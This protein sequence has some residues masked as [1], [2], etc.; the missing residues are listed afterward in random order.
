MKNTVFIQ[1]SVL[2]LICSVSVFFGCNKKESEG[3]SPDAEKPTSAFRSEKDPR[4]DISADSDPSE[5]IP[6]QTEGKQAFSR[7]VVL[8]DLRINA[9]ASLPV[10]V[11]I[12]EPRRGFY[13]MGGSSKYHGS[14]SVELARE[15]DF[16]YYT[17]EYGK[18]FLCGI[19][20]LPKEYA[21]DYP[22][23]NITRFKRLNINP[24]VLFM[25]LSDEG[26]SF[27]EN[28]RKESEEAYLYADYGIKEGDILFAELDEDKTP[29]KQKYALVQILTISKNPNRVKL[30]VFITK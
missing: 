14:G 5:I 22:E 2:L 18:S 8:D 23:K 1:R 27:I 6:G 11:S 15:V 13:F 7:T 21:V 4:S 9:A 30:R 25:A 10:F 26:G 29:D 20:H 24:F 12:I 16:A 3:I 19:E 28:A 17:T